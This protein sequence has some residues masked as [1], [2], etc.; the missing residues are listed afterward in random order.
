MTLAHHFFKVLLFP[1]RSRVESNTELELEDLDVLPSGVDV[2]VLH[3]EHHHEVEEESGGGGE[4]PDVVVVEE[5]KVARTV[6]LP[7]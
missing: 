7:V 5:Q 3:G 4:V 6:L 1:I 2:V